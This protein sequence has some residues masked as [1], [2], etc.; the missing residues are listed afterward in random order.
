MS[1][2]SVMFGVSYC[3]AVYGIDGCLIRVEA[4]I[5]NGLPG[6]SMVGFLAS[7][8]KE[9]R[10]RVQI[11]MKN[12][13]ILLPPKKI[14][15]NLSPADIRKCGTGYDLAIAVSV[16]TAFGYFSQQYVKKILFIGELGLEGDVKEVHGVLPM[17]YTAYEQGIEWC[18]VPNGNLAEAQ[19]VAGMHVI[20]AGHLK[21]LFCLLR[22][23]SLITSE[24]T[25]QEMDPEEPDALLDF[26]DVCGQ[27]FV[28]RA[29]LI[30]AAGRHNLLMVGP[31]GS[32]K[33][34]IAK[35]FPGIL[36]EM[37]FEEQMEVSKIYSVAGLLSKD[38][39]CIKKRPFRAPHHTITKQALVGGGHI[40][41]PGEISLASGGVLFLDELAEFRRE[42]IEV[43][44][45]P[46]EEGYVNIARMEGTYRYPAKCQL[47]AATNPCRCGFY[48]DRRKCICTEKQVR[49]YFD[50][51]SGPMIE[52]IDLCVE[53][54]PLKYQDFFYGGKKDGGK[55]E[56]SSSG[57][58]RTKVLHAYEL[59]KERYRQEN[60]CHNAF[61]PSNLL[62]KYCVLTNEAQEYLSE[63]FSSL[64][65]SARVYHKLLKVARTIADLEQSEKV[66]LLH[67]A[68]AVLYRIFDKKFRGGD[69]FDTV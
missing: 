16:L 35:R 38:M 40:P 1:E 59:Q 18:V 30:A 56:S 13:G 24:S 68:E 60:F 62:E 55:K 26:K 58:L 34:M 43:L 29:A 69:S 27:D 10:E 48:P 42:T 57:I 20:G 2:R 33:T 41:K 32:G 45:Q 12:S 39:P 36:P 51:I 54:Q 64:E 8:V 49:S 19:I 28:K 50:K 65:L 67:V 61:I 25:K 3:A 9:A 31:P 52:R 63:I 4:D 66:G 44:R 21:E 23:E 6:F 7:E 14:T 17:V 37:S 15:L 5:S 53:M 11:A 46:L 47:V 22:D